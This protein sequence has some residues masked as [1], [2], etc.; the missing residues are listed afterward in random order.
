MQFGVGFRIFHV[1][2]HVEIERRKLPVRD[3][4]H[5]RPFSDGQLDR[6]LLGYGIITR[7]HEVDL[8]AGICR[9]ELL[10]EFGH[11]LNIALIVIG[12]EKC[13]RSVFCLCCCQTEKRNKCYG[14][15]AG[16]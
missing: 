8:H 15:N 11:A 6:Q 5:I 13:D 7:G 14:A 10:A 12:K 3:L 4:G 16:E 1:G 2:P 9:L